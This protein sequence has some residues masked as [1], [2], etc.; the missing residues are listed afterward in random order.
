MAV[1]FLIPIAWGVGALLLKYAISSIIDNNPDFFSSTD[2]VKL[3]ILGLNQSGKTTLQDFLRDTSKVTPGGTVLNGEKVNEIRITNNEKTIIL[4]EGM[5]PS[6]APEGLRLHL[7]EEIMLSDKIFFLIKGDEFWEKDFY[8]KEN[9]ALLISIV[10]KINE[11]D[12]KSKIWIYITHKD[13]MK[14]KREDKIKQQVLNFL[15]KN[16]REGINIKDKIEKVDVLDLT[17]DASLN[18]LKQDLFKTN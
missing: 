2:K 13:K 4:L 10:K 7:E 11:Y 16:D 15:L 17:S 18:S 14:E 12:L 8:K 1:Q 5:D 9:R 6:G 3:A